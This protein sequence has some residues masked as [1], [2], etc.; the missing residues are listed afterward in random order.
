M[1]ALGDD[2]VGRPK[3]HTVAVGLMLGAI[4]LS[5]ATVAFWGGYRLGSRGPALEGVQALQ[6]ERDGLADVL[7]EARQEEI[8]CQRI[9]EIDQERDLSTQEQLK[10]G[11]DERLALV[12]EVSSLKRTIRDGGKGVVAVQ[13]LRL[14][15]TETPREF[16]YSFTLSQLI[17][18]FGESKGGV[19]LKLTGKKGGKD[20]TL[21]LKQLKGSKPARLNMNFDHF[22]NFEGRLV[23][24]EGFEPHTLVIEMDPKGAK[25]VANVE[26]FPWRP[27]DRVQHGPPK[28]GAP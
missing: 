19:E 7:A 5:I 10:A 25:L 24:P 6:R 15:A 11:Q 21:S 3:G 26:T 28:R 2:G 18:G 8:L 14:S 17:E 13:D 9:R 23:L 4:G 22:Q 27:G 20:E 12:K 16:R 1:V